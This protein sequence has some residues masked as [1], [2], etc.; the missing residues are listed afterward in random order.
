MAHKL[1]WKAQRRAR[2][3]IS[4]NND[5]ILITRTFPDAEGLQCRYLT[6]KAETPCR[7]DVTEISL[8]CDL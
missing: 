6:L 4:A 5:D 2:R 7:R 8:R 1:V 3:A